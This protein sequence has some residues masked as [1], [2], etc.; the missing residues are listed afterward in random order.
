MKVYKSTTM[1]NIS[2]YYDSYIDVLEEYKFFLDNSTVG[3][4]IEYEVLEMTEAEFN[5]IS[6]EEKFN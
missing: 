5:A 6:N 2:T 3:D 4:K 1:D